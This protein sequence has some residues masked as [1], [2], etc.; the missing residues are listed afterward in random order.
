MRED[1]LDEW[2][3]QNSGDDLEF[4]DAVRAVLEVEL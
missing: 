2:L 4:S 1:L 3:L